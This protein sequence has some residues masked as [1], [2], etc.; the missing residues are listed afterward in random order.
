MS[1]N[2]IE[3]LLLTDTTGY[4]YIRAYAGGPLPKPLRGRWTSFAK[5]EKDLINYLV[6]TDK[7]QHAIYP[8]ATDRRFTEY[9]RRHINVESASK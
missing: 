8:G 3:Y 5:C 4:Y 9:H 6:R 7:L 1:G 2:F